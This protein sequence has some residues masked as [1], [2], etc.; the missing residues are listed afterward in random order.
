VTTAAVLVPLVLALPLIAAGVALV[1][2]RSLLAQ[3]AVSVTAVAAVLAVTVAV[4]VLVERDGTVAVQVGA[5]PAPYGIT[6]VADLFSSLL[7]AVSVATALGVLV[8]AIGQLDDIVE[9]RF[10]HP[11]YLVL[12]AGV[13]ASFL[14]GDLFNLFVAF[15]V[16]LIASYVL[17]TIGGNR[18]SIRPA[19]TY[20]VINLL[21]STLFITAVG[22]VYAATGTVNMADLTGRMA[23]LPAQLQLAL[24]CCSSSSSA[25]RRRCSPCSSGCRTATRPRLRRSPRSSPACS[26]RSGC[27]RSSGRRRS[28]SARTSAARAPSC[29]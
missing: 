25:S 9:R 8:F 17:M 19:M 11:L 24:G 5:W 21:A 27:T 7:L 15:E 2:H 13:G 18:S 1:F 3:R 10:F 20:V 29:C 12:T 22:L 26:R 16:M 28:S 14:T 4:L 23:E 6:L